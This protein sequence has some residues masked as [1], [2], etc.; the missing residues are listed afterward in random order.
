MSPQKT[1]RKNKVLIASLIALALVFLFVVPAMATNKDVEYI[2]LES[3]QLF[4]QIYTAVTLVVTV[5]VYFLSGARQGNDSGL[6]WT[7]IVFSL[8]C[9]AGILAIWYM[10]DKSSPDENYAD[11]YNLMKTV[12]MDGQ[13]EEL[14]LT[15]VK[16]APNREHPIHVRML[17]SERDVNCM[18]DEQ[19]KL[20]QETPNAESPLFI[21][22]GVFIQSL[23]F[24]SANNVVVTGYVWQ[25]YPADLPE[26]VERGFILPEGDEEIYYREDDASYHREQ[27]GEEVLGWYIHTSLRQ[28]FDY[29]KYPFDRQDIWLRFWHLNFDRNV[30]LTPDFEAYGIKE[31]PHKTETFMGLER[32]FVLERLALER[33]YFN[34]HYNNYNVNF[35][36]DNYQGQSAFPELYFNVGVKR[37]V[38][39]AVVAYLI[40][41]FI[42]ILMSFGVQLIVTQIPDKMSMHGISTT[43]L[44]AYYA[45]LFFIGILA[46]LDVRRTL[47]APG[48]VYL[49]YFYF[50]LYAIL[51]LQTIN[52]IIFAATDDVGFLEYKDNLYPKVIFF[53]LT[54]GLMYVITAFLFF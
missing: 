11:H 19:V 27:N 12:P 9:L 44:I 45:S 26:F 2:P 34:Y 1:G 46:Q 3:R 51:L 18:K 4:I 21:T 50:M 14:D 54:M 42:L 35:G 7:G 28:T 37:E 36:V 29:G 17:D 38:L 20:A 10:V 24:T 40:P 5:A 16:S 52:S 48:V 25:K 30:I 8:F 33:T 41:M 13:C 53:P 39:D 47:N 31:W 23:E 32:D 43:G 15:T 6:W 49:E 22:T